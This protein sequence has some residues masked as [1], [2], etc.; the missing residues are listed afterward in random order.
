MSSEPG[1]I[2][3]SHMHGCFQELSDR[4]NC[5]IS[6]GMGLFEDLKPNLPPPVASR[7]Q[8]FTITGII[9]LLFFKTTVEAMRQGL[10]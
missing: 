9:R 8:I 7:L 2:M 10:E 6:P 4:S 1:Q 5:N 3:M